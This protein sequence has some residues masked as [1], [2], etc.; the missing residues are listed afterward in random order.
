M[1]RGWEGGGAGEEEGGGNGLVWKMKSKFFSIKSMKKKQN[2]EPKVSSPKKSVPL[3]KKK[4]NRDLVWMELI[5][6]SQQR[7]AVRD[8]KKT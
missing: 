2:G 5:H 1:D 3:K 7:K 4:R 8:L 6:C